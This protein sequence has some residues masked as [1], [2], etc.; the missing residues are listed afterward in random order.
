MTT[1]LNARATAGARQF[2]N[3]KASSAEG[4]VVIIA[5]KEPEGMPPEE[6]QPQRTML[7][8]SPFL[9][10]PLQMKVCHLKTLSQAQHGNLDKAMKKFDYDT[11]LEVAI[12]YLGREAIIAAPMDISV[13][14]DESGVSEI[15]R[16]LHAEFTQKA[17]E[18]LDVVKA[19]DEAAGDALD[20][21]YTEMETVL[22]QLAY[23]L[24]LR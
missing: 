24:E 6:M 20:N 19:G 7:D 10:V 23:R 3:K 8:V 16:N 14:A 22:S 18:V 2:L 17:R 9:K 21:V 13:P 4:S 15:I 1:S 12:S 5:Q 11:F